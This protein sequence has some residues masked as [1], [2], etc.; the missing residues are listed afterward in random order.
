LEY[1]T[2]T[3]VDEQNQRYLSVSVYAASES[4][5]NERLTVCS[6]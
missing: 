6:G 1:R 3:L 5:M 2:F 4:E